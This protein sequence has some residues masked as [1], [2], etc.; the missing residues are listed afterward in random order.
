MS[1]IFVGDVHIGNHKR[2][3]GERKHGMNQRCRLVL[4]AL[5]SALSGCEQDDHVFIL[6][7]LFNSPYVDARIIAAVQYVFSKTLP[8]NNIHVL[9]GNH[10]V[11]SSTSGDNVLSALSPVCD[12]IDSPKVV[13][14]PKEDCEVFCIPYVSD[15][16]INTLAD[17]VGECIDRRASLMHRVLAGHFGLRHS[18]INK[19]LLRD[20]C[21]IH[22]SYL[23]DFLYK[24]RINN[25]FTGHWHEA[26]QY[27]KDETVLHQLGALV[28]NGWADKGFDPYGHKHW[29]SKGVWS[30][31]TVPGP[32]FSVVFYSDIDRFVNAEECSGNDVFV[33]CWVDTRDPISKVQNHLDYLISAGKLCWYEVHQ[34]DDGTAK[35]AANVGLLP[36]NLRKSVVDYVESMDLPKHL[37]LSKDDLIAKTLTYIESSL[38]E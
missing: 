10:D 15:I 23:F 29:L 11:F 35:P 4:K 16:S 2:G 21:A 20:K 5:M 9:A 24:H 25:L 3:G 19:D 37:E 18:S 30:S 38:C 28:P 31:C 12:V 7:D 17:A 33:E 22:T 32:R 36:T 34:L 27:G 13:K 14:I 26:C 6:G 1:V 8:A